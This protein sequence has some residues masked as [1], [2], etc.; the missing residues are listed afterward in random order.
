MFESPCHF[1]DEAGVNFGGIVVLNTY[2]VHGQLLHEDLQR[3]AGIEDHFA[4]SDVSS[5]QAEEVIH[6]FRI[7]LA[8]LLR[9]QNLARLL[10]DEFESFLEQARKLWLLAVLCEAELDSVYEGPG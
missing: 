3:A 5:T 10:A 6:K 9:G 7:A 8:V 4:V 1:N 2:R